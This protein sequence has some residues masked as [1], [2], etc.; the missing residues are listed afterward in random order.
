MKKRKLGTII[1]VVLLALVMCFALTAAAGC[2]PEEST[3]GGGTRYTVTFVYNDGVTSNASVRVTDGETVEK[4]ADPTRSGY[5]FGGWYSNAGLTTAY[6]FSSA[7]TGNL[8]LYAKWDSSYTVT[9]VYNDGATA[10][11]TVGVTEGGTLEKPSD[12]TRDGYL[13][14][15]WYTDEALTTAYDFTSAVSGSFT[16]YARWISSQCSVTFNYNYDGAPEAEVVNVEA[17][18]TV[19]EPDEPTRSGYTFGGWYLDS[20]CTESYDFSAQ[21]EGDLTLYAFWMEEGVTYYTVTLRYGEDV[22]PDSVMRVTSGSRIQQP[23]DPTRDG[24]EFM[25]WYSDEAMT[26]VFVFSTRIEEDTTLYAKWGGIYLFE[27]ED[28]DIS[29]I[30]GQGYSGPATG[31]DIIGRGAGSSNG[32]YLTYLY[33]NGVEIVFEITSSAAVNDARLSLS[34]SAEYTDFTINGDTYQVLVNDTP[35]AY[36]IAF[37]GVPTDQSAAKME[38]EWYEISLNVSLKEGSNTIKLVTNNSDPLMGTMRATAPMVDCMKIVSASE[39]DWND[40]L[41]Y[42]FDNTSTLG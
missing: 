11:S 40:D 13:F 15:G 42:P 16:L 33:S 7:V 21:V 25:G 37:T 32:F 24:Y 1:T 31:S 2:G 8:T 26:Q 3:G 39:L 34:L 29:G 35:L 4:P 22:R 17:L 27:A 41:G 36:E 6:D 30:V 28:T 9:F 38:F 12:P 5:V 23:A 19:A 20:D 10:D 18:G 14:G